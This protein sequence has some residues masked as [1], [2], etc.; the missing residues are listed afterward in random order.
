MSKQGR[1]LLTVCAAVTALCVLLLCLYFFGPHRGTAEAAPPLSQSNSTPD[2]SDSPEYRAAREW[3]D[4]TSGYDPD[5]SILQSSVAQGGM[6]YASDY[7]MYRVYS[8][9]LAEKLEDIVARYAL[10][11]HKTMSFCYG[12]DEL[13]RFAGTGNFLPANC[14]CM[15]YIYDNGSFHFEGSALLDDT[16]VGYQFDRHMKGVF[17]EFPLNLAAETED[18]RT[19]TVDGISLILTTGPERCL[20]H[21]ELPL[22]YVTVTV[23]VGVQSEENPNGIPEDWLE[24]LAGSFRWSEIG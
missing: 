24:F 21:T 8:R 14:E 22:S 20:I 10:S 15:G 6:D 19:V 2:Y 16:T 9:E 3:L 13:C 12:G 5:G 4:F 23:P 1:V 17:S 18:S 7:T 11:L